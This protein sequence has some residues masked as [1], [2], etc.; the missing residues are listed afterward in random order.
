MNGTHI[1]MVEQA[2]VE[3]DSGHTNGLGYDQICRDLAQ[4]QPG[5][6]MVL[7]VAARAQS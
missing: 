5:S 2:S 4:E 7:K 1:S 6:A 3:C